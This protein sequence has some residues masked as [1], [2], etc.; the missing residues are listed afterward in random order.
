MHWQVSDRRPRTSSPSWP[1]GLLVRG[2]VMHMPG[3]YTAVIRSAKKFPKFVW[4]LD[5]V[6]PNHLQE[7]SSQEFQDM[8]TQTTCRSESGKQVQVPLHHILQVIRGDLPQFDQRAAGCRA[9]GLHFDGRDVP[10]NWD[11]GRWVP[12]SRVLV[13]MD[14][15]KNPIGERILAIAQH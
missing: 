2:L 9:A 5:S 13:G 4:L 6:R 3:H 11:N 14:T 1:E 10:G 12:S 8:A 15:L 7:L